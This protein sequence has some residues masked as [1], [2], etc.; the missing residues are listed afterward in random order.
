MPPIKTYIFENKQYPSSII[1]VEAY[2]PLKASSKIEL[3]CR[4]PN[5]WKLKK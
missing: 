3:I 1:T 5:D 2:T 4:Y